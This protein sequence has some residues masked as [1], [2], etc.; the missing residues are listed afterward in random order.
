MFFNLR[1]RSN[2]ANFETCISLYYKSFPRFLSVHMKGEE[3]RLGCRSVWSQVLAMGYPSLWSQVLSGEGLPSS[4]VTGPAWDGGGGEEQGTPAKTGVHR[5]PRR[6]H[7]ILPP[8][9]SPR[10]DRDHLRTG[11][12]VLLRRGRSA[13]CGYPRGLLC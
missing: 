7:C 4:P 2:F 6:G 12:R 9:P 8:P 13:S 3:G 1:K 5:P 10:Q 11:E